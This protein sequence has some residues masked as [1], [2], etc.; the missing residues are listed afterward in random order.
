MKFKSLTSLFMISVVAC[1][2][3][4]CCGQQSK[5]DK[6]Q[7]CAEVQG[8]A[9]EQC[10]AQK[11]GCASETGTVSGGRWQI[12][13]DISWEP[14]GEGVTRQIMGYNNNLM[15]VKVAFEK[16]GIGTAHQ[17]PHSQASYVASG[18]FE[19]TISGEKKILE[20][21]DGYYVAP[22]E[23]HGCVCLEAGVLID[24][25]APYREDFLK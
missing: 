15:I 11:Q 13:A 22:N 5:C 14:A 10:C 4:A 23:V 1:M 8:C 20:A 7:G 19:L 6:K 18:K 16:G 12:G 24:T 21:G 9:K 2:L 25:F 3:T 17:H